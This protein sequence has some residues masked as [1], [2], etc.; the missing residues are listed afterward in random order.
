M[1]NIIR[2]NFKTKQNYSI[3][4]VTQLV[5]LI[6]IHKKD[7]WTDRQIAEELNSRILDDAEKQL[8][9][10]V[11]TLIDYRYNPLI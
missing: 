9:T 7:Y 4:T 1:S 5:D 2:V 11:I 6:K 8:I 3:L 10:K